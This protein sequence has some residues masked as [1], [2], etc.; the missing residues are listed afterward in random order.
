LRPQFL[1][2]WTGAAGGASGAGAGSP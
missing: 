1:Y 2:L